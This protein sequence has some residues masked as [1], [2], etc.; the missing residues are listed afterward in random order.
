MVASQPVGRGAGSLTRLR[1]RLRSVRWVIPALFLL[2]AVSLVLGMTMRPLGGRGPVH[3][4][5]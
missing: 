4:R 2:L 3:A 5:R 1:W